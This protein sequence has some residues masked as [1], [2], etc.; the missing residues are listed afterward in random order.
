TSSMGIEMAGIEF[1]STRCCSAPTG[2]DDALV[3]G[4]A[5]DGGLYFAGRFPRLR[6]DS[7]LAPLADTATAVLAPWFE[8]SR[9]QNRLPAMCARAFAFDAPL[10]PLRGDGDW[11]LELFHGPT[12]AFKDYAAR[13][14]AEALAGLR[15]ANGTAT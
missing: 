12:A 2:I 15:D 9:L 6:M 10:Y 13:F 3:A 4:L 14:L 11:L 5:P 7:P 8:G 1:E